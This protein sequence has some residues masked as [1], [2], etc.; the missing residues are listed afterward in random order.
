MNQLSIRLVKVK[1]N[2]DGLIFWMS[3]NSVLDPTL[4]S[5]LNGSG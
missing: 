5:D 3:S 1:L 4:Y 2:C